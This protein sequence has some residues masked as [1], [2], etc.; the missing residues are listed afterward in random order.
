MVK[1]MIVKIYKILKLLLDILFSI[2]ALILISPL[3]LILFI[4]ILI[5]DGRP[6]I[7]KSKRIGINKNKFLVYKFRTLI[8]GI[9]RRE[10]GLADKIVIN[11][12]AKFMRD[13]HLD[14]VLQLIN[15]IKGDIALI[16]PRP[17]DLE[18]Y[19]HL[20][21]NNHK[22]DSIFKIKPGMTCL[23]QIARYSN[24]GFEKVKR[25]KGLSRM[26]RRNRLRL[27]LY[28]IK[29]ESIFLDLK[30]TFWTIEYL[31]ICFFKKMFK[32]G[33]LF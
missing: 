6:I 11:K 26:K 7:F 29:N 1:W 19:Y 4:S 3:I 9:K 27:D 31:I 24:K 28:Y 17:L 2:I 30:I 14:E 15:V 25:L 5:S 13:T 18:R 32:K 21:S 20:K 10:D 33:A 16:G 12:F 23:N 22:W 8:N